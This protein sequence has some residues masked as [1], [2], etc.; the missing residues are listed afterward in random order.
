[1]QRVFTCV[2]IPEKERKVRERIFSYLLKSETG[3][4]AARILSD[5]FKIH[6]ANTSSSDSV[7]AGLLGQD[8]RFVFADGLWNLSSSS[9]APNRLESATTVVLHLQIANCS[10]A[11]WRFRGALMWSDGRLQEVRSP[12]SFHAL[13]KLR[14]GM[15]GSLLL[16][17]S[18]REL[19]LWNRLLRSANIESWSGDKLF[20]RNLAARTLN[21]MP[22]K[23]RL[24]ELA[25]ELGVS[26]AD[27]ERPC[28]VARYLNECWLALRDRIPAE[29]SRSFDSLREWI[30]DSG[31]GVDFSHFG[32]GLD[33]LRQLPGTSGVYLMKDSEGNVIYVGK[34]RNLKRRISSYFTPRALSSPKNARIHRRLHSI[35][36]RRTDNEVEALLME[37]RLIAKFRPAVNLQT[38]IHER[39]SDFHQGRNLLLFVTGAEQRGVRIY[40]FCNGTYAGWQTASLGRPPAEKLIEKIQSLFFTQ[41]LPEKRRGKA[42]EKEIVS[43]W[44]TTNRK[45]LN[46]LDVDEAGDFRAL[47]KQLGRYL[48]DPDGLAHKVYYR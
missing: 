17:W 24:E 22:S 9:R 41:C 1:M 15:E 33:F 42:W 16:L 29:A 11:A 47:L 7:L 38:E 19:G 6:S 28:D 5:V 3:V 39:Q 2:L 14:R 10:E 36:L 13:G 35:D 30:G 23:L 8:S 48:C 4:P 34:S 40:F 27:E 20:L 44:L 31:P 21:R 37:M 26:P 32:F 12:E 46:Y 45:R 25:S 18:S 43:R